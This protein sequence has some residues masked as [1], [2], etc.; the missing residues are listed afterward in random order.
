MRLAAH[1]D[2]AL[3]LHQ[4]AS[5]SSSSAAKT[6]TLAA[7]PLGLAG[8]AHHDAA[9]TGPDGAAHVLLHR[10]LQVGLPARRRRPDG[11]R[12]AA[13]ALPTELGDAEPVPA[14]GGLTGERGE[15][16][17]RP[18]G[19]GLIGP[20][21]VV[22]DEVGHVAALTERP[23]VGR[24][25]VLDLVGQQ[26]RRVDLGRRRGPEQEDDLAPVADRLI[27]QHPDAGDPQP[28]CDQQQVLAPRIDL[29]RA[30][31]R[32]EHVHGVAGPEPGEPVGAPADRPDSGS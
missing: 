23:V 5:Q 11:I 3:G 10:Y 31:E 9:E 2:L 30:T 12:L 28:A 21:L 22:R 7:D 32:P 29:E 24:D 13:A 27:G 25:D 4:P 16:R 8:R 19:E 26:V 1:D 14:T 20:R 18:A 6:G 17:G 15:H